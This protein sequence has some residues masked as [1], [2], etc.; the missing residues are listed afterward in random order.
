MPY[1]LM[2]LEMFIIAIWTFYCLIEIFSVHNI[3]I[4]HYG[5]QVFKIKAKAM[6]L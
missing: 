2:S 4:V 1:I 6:L 3:M 5:H